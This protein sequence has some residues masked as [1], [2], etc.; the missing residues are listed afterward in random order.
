MVHVE[1]FGKRQERRR[2]RTNTFRAIDVEVS[3][4]PTVVH[5]DRPGRARMGEKWGRIVKNFRGYVDLSPQ[6]AQL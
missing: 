2:L 3:K 1:R 5:G 4:I 6:G